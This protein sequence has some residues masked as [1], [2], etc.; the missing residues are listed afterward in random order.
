MSPPTWLA[1]LIL[2]RTRGG[3]WG[4]P[5]PGAEPASG[6]GASVA[7][8]ERSLLGT[9]CPAP[10]GGGI[11]GSAPFRMHCNAAPAPS[12]GSLPPHFGSAVFREEPKATEG[13]RVVPALLSC[14]LCSG[15]VR[16]GGSWVL[17]ALSYHP[18]RDWHPWESLSLHLDL[19][20]PPGSLHPAAEGTES[21]LAF[22]P[23]PVETPS[24]A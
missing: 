12:G 9:G 19:Q 5:C 23:E 21:P 6:R 15:S 18:G 22:P 20:C 3:G 2:V 16:G 10:L 11:T 14:Q 4:R 17:G 24:Q 1:E 13:G 8:V 7:T